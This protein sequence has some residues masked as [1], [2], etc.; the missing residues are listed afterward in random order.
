MDFLDTR[1]RTIT[2]MALDGLYERQKAIASNTAN[3]LTPNYRR[4]EVE[5]EAQLQKKIQEYDYQEEVKIDNS[6][7]YRENPAE[8]LKKFDIAQMMFRDENEQYAPTVREDTYGLDGNGNNV[9][10][11]REMMQT[12]KT[13]TQY[14]ILTTL[15]GSSFDQL[16]QV[17]KGQ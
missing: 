12:A 4:K 14:T 8:A 11:E 2:G 1:T 7:L 10:L 6:N 3:A 16:E 5:F 13:G 9:S 17:I 15:L